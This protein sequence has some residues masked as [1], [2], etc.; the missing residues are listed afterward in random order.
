MSHTPL[1]DYD[2]SSDDESADNQHTATNTKVQQDKK[3]ILKRK[4]E[5]DHD[6]SDSKQQDTAQNKK[7]ATLKRR[8]PPPPEAFHNLFPRSNGPRDNPLQHQGRIRAKPHIRGNWATHVYLSIHPSEELSV[9]LQKMF[10]ATKHSVPGLQWIQATNTVN[11]MR[12]DKQEDG[13]PLDL[14][15]RRLKERLQDIEKFHINFAKIVRFDN[16]EL[17]REFISLSVGHGQPQASNRTTSS[18]AAFYQ[19]AHFHA[20]FAWCLRETTTEIDTLA[21]CAA[22]KAIQPMEQLA[23]ASSTW[24][25][26]VHCRMGNRYWNVSLK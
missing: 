26:K 25:T 14:F 13:T 16:E 11:G 17:T 2:T 15:T 22:E 6:S 4:R 5:T 8:P 7:D 19:P 23:R 9:L 21:I 18:D 1:V 24:I 3:D 20:S 12:T 10:K